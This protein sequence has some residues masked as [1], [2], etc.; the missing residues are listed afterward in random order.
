MKKLNFK[1][2]IFILIGLLVIL[3]GGMFL[4]GFGIMAGRNQRLTDKLAQKTLE[5][6]VLK[7]EQESFE[8][9][10]IDLAALDKASYP[11]EE[12]FS[13]DTKLVKEIQQLESVAQLYSVG[14]IT[15]ISGTAEAAEKVQG[16]KGDLF[17]VP[18]TLTLTGDFDNVMLFIQA[19]EHLPFVTKVQQ[20]TISTSGEVGSS[21]I[22]AAEFYIKK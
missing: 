1:F 19:M 4:F 11:P 7:R 14:L 5:L 6:E 2:K 17:I 15:S 21:T 18:Y 12:L 16:T 20:L 9:G 22:V 8:Q 3:I 10:K 13:S